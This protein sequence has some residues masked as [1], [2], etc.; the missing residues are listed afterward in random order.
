MNA[1]TYTAARQRLAELMKTVNSDHTQIH[2]TQKDGDDIII[3]SKADY[4]AMQETMYLMSS[5]R[6]AQRLHESIAEFE[7]GH[8]LEKS[9]VEE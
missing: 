9:L 2:V 8:G 5:P 1:L 3:M 7:A 6:N 4:D